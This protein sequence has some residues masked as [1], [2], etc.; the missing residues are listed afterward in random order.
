MLPLAH[1]RT[2]GSRRLEEAR[3]G[4]SPFFCEHKLVVND[5]VAN[6]DARHHHA[7]LGALSLNYLQYGSDI[8]IDTYLSGFFL[9]ETP[10]SGRSQI[11]AGA[12]NAEGTSECGCVISP[13]RALNIRWS[14]DCR[15]LMLRIDQT[16]VESQLARLLD[17]SLTAPLKFDLGLR[18]GERGGPTLQSMLNYMFSAADDPATLYASTHVNRPMVECFV[19]M[20]LMGQPHNYSELLR[21]PV[22]PPAPRYVRRAEEVMRARAKEAPTL[23]EIARAT[24]IGVRSLQTGFKRFRGTTPMAYLRD[25]RLDQVRKWLLAP[26]EAQRIRDVALNWGF[27]DLSRFASD[28]RHR[29]G[30]LPRETL[31]TASP[32]RP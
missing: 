29:F 20:L 18:F 1:C 4:I 17:R 25:Y 14:A 22:K 19:T 30:E 6:F 26:T 27:T 2:F 12:D 5:S 15:K 21:Q 28:Y 24:G 10:L 13:D 11:R 32:A 7:V 9:I 23:E 3:A 8:T 16:V 31:R